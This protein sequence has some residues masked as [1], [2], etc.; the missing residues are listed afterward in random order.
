MPGR[1]PRRQH[2]PRLRHPRQRLPLLGDLPLGRHL[3]RQGRSGGRQRPQHPV[4]RL[5]GG[6]ALLGEVDPQPLIHVEAD[7]AL[8]TATGYTFYGSLASAQPGGLD[9]REPLGSVWGVPTVDRTLLKTRPDRLARSRPP[10]PT[11]PTPASPA[12]P[13]P[14]GRRCRRTRSPASTSRR[15]RPSSA[16]ATNVSRWPPSGSRPDRPGIGTPS[17]RAGAASTS[18]S[19]VKAP[20]PATPI[21]PA[22][23]PRA[24]SPPSCAAAAS[25]PRPR[26]GDA[27]QRLRPPL[28]CPA[29]RR[30][31]RPALNIFLVAV[32]A[33]GL[34]PPRPRFTPS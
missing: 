1:Q 9:H 25:A 19:P 8:E 14:T 6:A 33:G 3:F 20:S 2:R 26:R 34:T 27:A 16:A 32:L 21:S 13:V 5:R 28:P 22:T 30:S 4:G 17:T 23:S 31:L 12:A 10:T 24:T 18:A 11:P 15:I 29:G 7:A